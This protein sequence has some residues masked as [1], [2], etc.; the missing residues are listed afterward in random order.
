ME[1]YIE[2]LGEI[3]DDIHILFDEENPSLGAA[4]EY[5]NPLV[6]SLHD[7]F[8]KVDMIMDPDVNKL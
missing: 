5:S 8:F 3:I 7:Q 6:H 4:R 1:S 2:N